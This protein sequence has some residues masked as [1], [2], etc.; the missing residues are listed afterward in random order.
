MKSGFDKHAT[1]TELAKR[2]QVTYQTALAAWDR[3]CGLMREELTG[4][5]AVRIEGVGLLYPQERKAREGMD[6]FRHERTF[7]PARMIAKFRGCPSLRDA[8]GKLPCGDNTKE[9]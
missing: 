9:G 1:V 2:M 4:G 5:K 3:V 6:A 7:F 8:L